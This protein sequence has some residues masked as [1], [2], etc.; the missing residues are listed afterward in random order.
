MSR[1]YKKPVI[2]DGSKGRKGRGRSMKSFANRKIRNIDDLPT[3]E[4]GAY[5][6]FFCSYDICDYKWRYSI[7]DAIGDWEEEEATYPRTEKRYVLDRDENGKLIKEDGEYSFS[8][9]PIYKTIE[10]GPLHKRFVTLENYLN[11]IIK[12]YYRK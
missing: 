2:T 7:D 10:Q 4:R 6:K 12:T 9:H 8:V 3:R 1:S 5:K 11:Y